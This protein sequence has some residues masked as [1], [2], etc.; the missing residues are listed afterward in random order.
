M[1]FVLVSQAQNKKWT[2]E[3]CV[4]YALENNISIK[5]SDLDSKTAA[6][7]KNN[8]FGNF[9]PTLNANASHS[10][11]IGLNQNITTGLLENQTTQFTSVGLTA[12]V[13]IYNGLQNQNRLR[14]ATLS[15][16]AAQYQLS[17]MK[18]DISLNIANAFL[19]ILFNKENLNVAKTQLANDQKL[20]VRTEALV[21]AGSLP[22][23]DL[24]DSKATIAADEQ[25]IVVAE[26]QLLIS[27]L[28]L[29]QLLQLKDFQ[30]FDIEDENYP[31]LVSEVMMQTPESIIQKAKEN[32]NE[33]K[34]A[35]T[36]VD[37]AEKDIKISKG[38]YQPTLEGFYSF[39]SRV[40]YSDRVVGLIPD[41][42]NPTSPIGFVEGTNQ[43]VVQP[44]YKTILGN[45][46]PFFDQFDNNKGHNF[47]LQ[48]RVPIFNGF[49][50]KNNVERSKV[51]LERS[52]IN[53]S[54]TELDLERAVY[55][56]V[57]DAKGAFNTM[58]SAI[59]TLEARE[60]AFNYAKERYAVGMMNAFDYNQAQLLYANAQSEVLRTKYD[61]IFR[62]KIVEFYFGLPITK[63]Q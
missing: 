4:N 38:A 33:L 43:V 7:E 17:K 10:W 61:Y 48:L 9:L 37:I 34:I 57:T 6:I 26:N 40:G 15:I 25:K 35:R 39:S 2:L 24:F 63:K 46:L 30:T 42:A 60:L 54:Q 56:A 23:G 58:Q 27:K 45:P 21:D 51:A 14:R 28:S 18:D 32:R 16:I 50:T 47:G 1:L 29:A 20:L 52:K 5:L 53:L 22:R 55:T 12:G 49:A 11:N 31:A 19:Q 36:N 8:A 13:T 62:T 41:T 44:N 59:V 3:E